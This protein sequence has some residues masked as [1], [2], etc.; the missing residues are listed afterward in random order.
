MSAIVRILLVAAT[1]TSLLWATAGIAAADALI[2]KTYKD[3]S[4][5]VSGWGAKPV[6]VSVVGA[7]MATDDCLVT[8]WRH[9]NFPDSAGKKRSEPAILL[10]L[11]CN[12]PYA[13]AGSP[14]PSL[15]SPEGRTAKHQ[16]DTGKW[17]S[18]PEQ[19]DFAPCVKFC[20]GF[21]DLCTV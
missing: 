10:G 16:I 17:C 1:A 9:S 5:T 20:K 2:G 13:S 18:E 3:A 21:A 14:G 4:A 7:R 12:G 6:I 19:A 15:G 11:N 8:S